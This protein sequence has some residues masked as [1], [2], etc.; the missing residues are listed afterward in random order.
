MIERLRRFPADGHKKR[1]SMII[2]G[3]EQF[4]KGR[5]RI[6]IDE[7]FAFVLYSGEIRKLGLRE[8]EEIS[9]DTYREITEE[10]LVKRVRLRAMN[11]LMKHAFTEKNLRTKLED[12]E[13]SQELIDNAIEYVSSFGYL[14][15]YAFAK[16]YIV[17]HR[18]DKSIGRIRNDLLNKGIS[19]DIINSAFEAVCEQDGAID[20]TALIRR[21]LDKRRFDA[22]TASFEEKNKTYAFLMGKGFSSEAIN[23]VIHCDYL[24]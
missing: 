18:D 24:T 1:M 21:I 14:D 16:D 19:R 9:E 11:L 23:R 13:Y 22:N 2:T 6:Y 5:Y 20:E 8:N 15:D 12:G 7:R 17:S 3:I 10:I 4:K